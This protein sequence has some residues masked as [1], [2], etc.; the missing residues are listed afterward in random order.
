[1]KFVVILGILMLLTCIGILF[2]TWYRLYTSLHF[3]VKPDEK[4]LKKYASLPRKTI[5]F[6]SSDGVKI[7]GWYVKADRPKAVVILVHGYETETGGKTDM[8][9]YAKFLRETGYSSLLIDLRS[10]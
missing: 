2:Y 5:S 1:M 6:V 7:A 3:H 9:G 8:L 4:N 10:F